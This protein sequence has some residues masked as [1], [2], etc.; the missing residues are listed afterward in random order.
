MSTHELRLHILRFTRQRV[1]EQVELQCEHP[2]RADRMRARCYGSEIY[3]HL[4]VLHIGGGVEGSLTFPA[5]LHPCVSASARTL[6]LVARA[7]AGNLITSP[8]RLA[9]LVLLCSN[10]P[11]SFVKHL[12]IA[13][14]ELAS[15]NARRITRGLLINEARCRSLARFATD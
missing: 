11:S 6:E 12:S 3:R 15:A 14:D 4:P 10:S 13:P 9:T 1:R 8:P 7:R 2:R 5:N